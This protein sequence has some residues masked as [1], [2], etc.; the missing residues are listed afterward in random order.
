MLQKYV[1]QCMCVARHFCRTLTVLLNITEAIRVYSD[2]ATQKKNHRLSFVTV[3][4]LEYVKPILAR[5]RTQ[6]KT[7]VLDIIVYIYCG[8]LCQT[9]FAVLSL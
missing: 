2:I 9:R 5:Q 3:A 8:I 7:T 1:C 4:L 6:R